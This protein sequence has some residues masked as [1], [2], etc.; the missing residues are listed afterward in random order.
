MTKSKAASVWYPRYPGDYARKT[1]H[2]S[3]TEHGVYALLMDHYYSTGRP[4]PANLV[5]MHRICKAL[6][7][8]EREA[9]Q[10]VLSEFFTLTPEGYVND[11]AAQE[12]A[13][14]QDISDK[15]REAQAA[16]E[17]ARLAKDGASAGA[18]APPLDDTATTTATSES[19]NDD[20]PDSV[21]DQDL[22]GDA[23]TQAF[24]EFN[25]FA[26]ERGLS[27]VQMVSDKRKKAMGAR[28]K[29]CGGLDGWKVILTD[30]IGPSDFL[31]GRKTDFKVTID[32]ILKKENFIKIMEGNYLNHKAPRREGA[33]SY[34]DQMF[35]AYQHNERK[36]NDQE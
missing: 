33:G 8:H 10:A 20:S 22:F 9:V 16:R 14:R 15:R 7:P 32:F 36:F 12:I 34:F 2:L 13:K 4:L 17:R 23:V 31:M 6:E 19:S 18:N 27:V 5:Q 29:E 25:I 26:H 21:P 11:R 28:L 3:L 35:A 24:A 1:S 30:I